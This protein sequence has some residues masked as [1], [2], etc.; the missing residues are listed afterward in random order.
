MVR[1]LVE[2]TPR[3]DE[4][5]LERALRHLS[6]SVVTVVFSPIIIEAFPVVCSTVLSIP[7]RQARISAPLSAVLRKF[8]VKSKR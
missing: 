1:A 2:G 4:A 6:S 3:N 5:G 8:R 7:T